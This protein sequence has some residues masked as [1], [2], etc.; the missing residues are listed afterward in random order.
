MRMSVCDCVF[1][2]SISWTFSAEKDTNLGDKL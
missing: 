2:I 1:V